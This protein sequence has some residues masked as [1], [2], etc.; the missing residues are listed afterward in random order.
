MKDSYNS[1]STPGGSTSYVFLTAFVAAVGGFLFGYDLNIIAG[2]QQYLRDYFALNSSQFG[3]TMASALLGCLLGPF[4]GA[5]ACDKLGRRKSLMV[6]CLLF[7]AGAIGTTFPRGI[8]AFNTFRIVGGMGVGL[9]SLASPMY[10]AEISP[11]RIRGMLVTMNQLAIV[12]G[13]LVAIVVSY[14][15][16][17]NLPPAISWRYM[18]ASMLIP[19]CVFALLLW[20]MPESP[21]WL[22][23]KNRFDEALKVLL[24]INGNQEGQNELKGIREEIARATHIPDV[25]LGELFIPGVRIALVVGI[26]LAIM[27]Q[28]TGWSMTAFYMP[29][30]F[31]QAG[32]I[33]KAHAVL[34]TII[35]NIANLIYTIIAIYLV[36]LVGRRLLYLVCAL[37]MTLTMT[38]LGLVFVFKMSGWPVVTILSLTAAPHAVGFGALCWLVLS[39]MFPT[40]IRAKAMSICTATV[41]IAC[42]L[43]TYFTPVLFD[44]SQ[45]L[46]R[47][48][49]GVFFL[50]AFVSFIS[51]LF[52]RKMLPETKGKSLEQIGESW[53][54]A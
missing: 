29:T 48:P 10:I 38:L 9:A 6:A 36:D 14:F 43:V 23:Q 21:R 4:L 19:V 1:P 49:S 3:W 35:P 15:L 18:F 40:R 28:W 25:A 7:G 2:A 27:S 52:L 51:F 13:S 37:A 11:R 5:W 32:I 41:W 31:R 26:A 44:L 20:K 42:F 16:A 45:K 39:E 47:I 50:C 17:Q 24:K 33:D 12:V 22:S 8:F 46:L 54:L 53:N 30:I 34:L